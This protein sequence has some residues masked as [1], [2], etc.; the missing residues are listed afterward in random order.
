MKTKELEKQLSSEQL[1]KLYKSEEIVKEIMTHDQAL[2]AM[3]IKTLPQKLTAE[4]II[5]LWSKDWKD[6]NTD[7]FVGVLKNISY[8]ELKK[9]KK[10]P[11]LIAYWYATPNHHLR[12]VIKI[13]IKERL[14]RLRLKLDEKL[15]LD[16]YL[17]FYNNHG[18]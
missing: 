18:S 9:I 4:D 17:I 12:A 13:I 11:Q 5:K 15:I 14:P 16:L 2:Q 6:I 1:L 10:L 3:F 8:Q 7:G